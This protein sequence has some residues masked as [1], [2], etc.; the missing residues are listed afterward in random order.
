MPIPLS[1][2]EVRFTKGGRIFAKLRYRVRSGHSR[3]IDDKAN[4]TTS[5]VCHLFKHHPQHWRI[6]CAHIH[7]V[8]DYLNIYIIM[9]MYVT[10]ITH[11][12]AYML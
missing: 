11:Y 4:L 3:V 2:L 10:T 5:S 6:M 12:S 9:W 8:V 1:F 7:H